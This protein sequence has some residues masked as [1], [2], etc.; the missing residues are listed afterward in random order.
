[1]VAGPSGRSGEGNKI[2]ILG[3]SGSKLSG[4]G[5]LDVWSSLS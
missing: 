2:A 1:M 3:I 5:Y 4:V